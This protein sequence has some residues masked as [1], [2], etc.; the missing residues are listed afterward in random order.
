MATTLK[1][2]AARR[3]GRVRTA[4]RRVAYGRPRL[5]VFRSAK[6]IYAQ[7]I[8]TGKSVHLQEYGAAVDRWFDVRIVRDE[9]GED[10]VG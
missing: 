8:D 1:S 5:S 10:F 3:K 6:Y 7:V 2:K 9:T 4:L